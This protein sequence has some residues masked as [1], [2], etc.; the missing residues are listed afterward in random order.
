MEPSSTERLRRS[1]GSE[2]EPGEPVRGGGHPAEETRRTQQEQAG[3]AGCALQQEA[4]EAVI[5]GENVFMRDV[6]CG[7]AWSGSEEYWK[8]WNTAAAAVMAP[9]P[10]ISAVSPGLR[11]IVMV[12]SAVVKH[13]FEQCDVLNP[14][15][16]APTSDRTRLLHN[17]CV[18]RGKCSLDRGSSRVR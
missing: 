18:N 13:A 3:K 5:K 12:N 16:R 1:R 8:V 6:L 10:A 17:L 11:V 2:A 7:V 4:T 15:A 9:V 14:P